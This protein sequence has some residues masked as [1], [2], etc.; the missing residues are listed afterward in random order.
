MTH[1]GVVAG[2]LSGDILGGGLLQE[3]NK[4]IETSKKL[5][6]SGITGPNLR[7]A[8][9]ESICDIEQLS[10][11]G[12]SE[13]LRALPRIYFRVYRRIF[14]YFLV[15]RP[16]LFIGIDS[17][18]F[19]LRL[20]GKLKKKGIK[21]VQYVSPTLWAWRE[22]RVKT[23]KKNVDHVL[24][25]LPFEKE[26]YDRHGVA[27]TYVGHPLADQIPLVSENHEDFQYKLALPQEYSYIALLPGSRMSE[28]KT[29]LPIFLDTAKLCYEKNVRLRFLIPAA[30]PR[31]AAFIRERVATQTPDLPV[32]ILNG[33]AHDVIRA[34]RVVLTASGTATLETMLLK[35]PMVVAYK[36]T[37]LT[38]WV[39]KKLVTTRY[40]SLPNLL[41]NEAIVPEYIQD[42]VEPKIM[43][44]SVLMLLNDLQ[45]TSLLL[46]KFQKIHA[47][48]RCNAHATAAAKV[49]SLL[50]LS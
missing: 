44:Q 35:R 16:Q 1:I 17:P 38:Y 32:F 22:S 3:L 9:C 29:L 48:L 30:N 43:A 21:T 34:S 12:I 42:Q 14:K 25:I 50:E 6:F 13:V 18:D 20:A 36:L 19:N 39:A 40:F 23:V 46:E 5:R 26:F 45:H 8:G 31:L 28:V 10:V 11:M 47:L 24:V 33:K 49:R 4:N 27:S 7:K 2:E 41:A 15:D 37:G